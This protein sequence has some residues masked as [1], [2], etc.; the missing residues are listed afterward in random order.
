MASQAE[1]VDSDNE[2]FFEESQVD[3][4]FHTISYDPP[5]NPAPVFF[6]KETRPVLAPP[7]EPPT[8]TNQ[9]RHD[10]CLNVFTSSPV[11]SCSNSHDPKANDR[12]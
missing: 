5:T 6:F 7:V 2:V 12:F 9:A 8:L 10:A 4:G 3:S 11:H 1:F